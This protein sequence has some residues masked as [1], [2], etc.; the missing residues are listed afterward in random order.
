MILAA[1]AFSYTYELYSLKLF[2]SLNDEIKSSSTG[3]DDE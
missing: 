3:F 1:R 2:V